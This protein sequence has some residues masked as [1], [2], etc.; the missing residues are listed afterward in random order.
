MSHDSVCEP[1]RSVEVR[2]TYD[3][4]LRLY[5]CVFYNTNF[6]LSRL[7]GQC[8]CQALWIRQTCLANRT[9]YY[10]QW[11][12]CLC[13][14]VSLV[15]FFFSSRQYCLI[16]PAFSFCLSHYRPLVLGYVICLQYRVDGPVSCFL[17]I[18][19][20]QRGYKRKSLDNAFGIRYSSTGASPDSEG[21]GA[22]N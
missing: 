3:F 10:R 12:S 16:S 15:V 22:T 9:Y 19:D 5:V 21:K 4:F 1:L 20:P 18:S 13:L 11:F 6:S 7:P 8:W 17:C 2:K 14:W